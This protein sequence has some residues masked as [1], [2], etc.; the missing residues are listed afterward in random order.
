MTQ[1]KR[2]VSLLDPAIVQIVYLHLY[3]ISLISILSIQN[4]KFNFL[5]LTYMIFLNYYTIGREKPVGPL[6]I[7]HKWSYQMPFMSFVCVFVFRLDK[8]LLRA[9]TFVY[10]LRL[11][12]YVVFMFSLKWPLVP[13]TYVGI[14]SHN[15]F[16]GRTH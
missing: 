9:R 13:N 16:Y 8:T 11:R 12:L 2:P 1:P 3:Y 15:T 6:I 14:T 4:L 7:K 5:K 10:I